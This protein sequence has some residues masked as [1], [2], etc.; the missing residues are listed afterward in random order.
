M[1]RKKPIHRYP[2]AYL[3]WFNRALAGKPVRVLH[4]DHRAVVNKRADLYAYREVLREE[5]GRT[6]ADALTF[7]ADGRFLVIHAPA[8]ATKVLQP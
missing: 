8:P 1:P 4:R 7:E 3:H 5:F 2:P 6:N